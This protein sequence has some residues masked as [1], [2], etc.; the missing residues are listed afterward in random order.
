MIGSESSSILYH[1]DGNCVKKVLYV[2]YGDKYLLIW[3]TAITENQI[4]SKRKLSFVE[5]HNVFLTFA[6][7]TLYCLVLLFSTNNVGEFAQSVC[8]GEGCEA[9][10]DENVFKSC[11]QVCDGYDND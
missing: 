4:K 3:E 8:K 6:L 2:G 1:F 11:L 10:S 7:I 5:S 9:F